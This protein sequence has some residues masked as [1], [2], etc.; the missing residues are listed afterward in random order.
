MVEIGKSL[1]V[2]PPFDPTQT[3]KDLSEARTIVVQP[4]A[5]ELA[6]LSDDPD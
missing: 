3:L 4:P 2:D 1:E 5:G 6:T